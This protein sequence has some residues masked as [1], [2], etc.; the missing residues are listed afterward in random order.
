MPG[1]TDAKR[2]PR[3]APLLPEIERRLGPRRPETPLIRKFRLL[4][5]LI[6]SFMGRIKICHDQ[7]QG[8]E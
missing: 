1:M 8:L 3:K 6:R 7:K 2:N 4:L 5:P